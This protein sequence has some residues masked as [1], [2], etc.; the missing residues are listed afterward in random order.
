M[1]TPMFGTEDFNII[2]P[3]DYA[4]RGYPHDVWTRLRREDP[5]HWW[6]RT[7]GIPFWA[8]TKRSDIVEISNK[9]HIFQNGPRVTISH[10]PENP[11]DEFPATLIQMDPPRHTV[12]RKLINKRFK[13]RALK[14]LHEPIEKIGKEIVDA[15]IEQSD[16]G[17]CDFVD[18]VSAPLPIAVI[19]WLLGVP[20][21]DW[22]RLFDWTN[23][24]I[25][26]QDPEYR[27]E[28]VEP[29]EAARATMVELFTYFAQLV[30]EKKKKPDDTLITLFTQMEVGG[31]KLEPMDVLAWCLIIVIAGNETT[32]NGTTGGMLAFIE[33]QDQLRKLQADPGLLDSAVEEVVR[34]STPIIHFAR[35]ATQDYEL[36]GKT[37]EAGQSVALFYPSANRDEDVFDDPFEFRIDRHPN[38]HVGFGNGEHFCLGAH[39]ARL[40]MK[41]AFKYLLP[42]IDEIELAGPVE[43]LK[44]TLV[45]GVKHL[46]IRYKLT[47]G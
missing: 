5:V 32:R 34:W 7:E 40:E 2:H 36:R 9:P 25:G 17:E 29:D 31:E 15:L 33:N 10:K 20:R 8:I 46:P 28:G 18:K 35:T 39:L 26:A 13:P 19:A 6:T 22:N 23:H 1:A 21:E 24:I 38:R 41:V 11:M 4:A 27:V 3:E 30:E 42:R 47:P 44:S 37:I 43:R 16:S 45:G 12:F 14:E